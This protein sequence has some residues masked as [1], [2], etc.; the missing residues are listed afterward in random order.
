MEGPDTVTTFFGLL[1]G[2][3][4]V[5]LG[6]R[7]NLAYMQGTTCKEAGGDCVCVDMHKVINPTLLTVFISY[8]FVWLVPSIF[9]FY[10]YS[11]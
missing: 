8:L 7:F 1:F 11:N 4:V 6:L 10:M 3:V 9:S 5:Y 2:M